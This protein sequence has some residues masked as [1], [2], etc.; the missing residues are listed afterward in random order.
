MSV[1]QVMQLV[2]LAMPTMGKVAAFWPKL[3]WGL[4]MGK[5]CNK[6]KGAPLFPGQESQTPTME[7]ELGPSG[8]QLAPSHSG[9]T[10][11]GRR[12][13]QVGAVRSSQRSC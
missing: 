12:V 8:G 13:G 5:F 3:R 11:E 10:W 9:R 7:R 4:E 6:P 2:P 1:E